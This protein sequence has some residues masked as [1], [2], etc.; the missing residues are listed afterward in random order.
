MTVKAGGWVVVVVTGTPAEDNPEPPAVDRGLT[1]GGASII[2]TAGPQSLRA[3]FV[4]AAS[5][6]CAATHA[7]SAALFLPR[8][9]PA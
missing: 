5:A 2:A 1:V 6:G 8:H 4:L 3:F 9:S 7:S